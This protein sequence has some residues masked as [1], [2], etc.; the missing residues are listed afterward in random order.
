VF[1]V[2]NVGHDLEKLFDINQINK[3]I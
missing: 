3:L 1:L 2:E